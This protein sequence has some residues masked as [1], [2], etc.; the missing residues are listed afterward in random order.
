MARRDLHNSILLAN[1]L[2]L[3]AIAN[4]EN[5]VGEIIDRQGFDSLEFVLVV[6]A[7]TDGTVTPLIEHGDESN[8]SDAVA[9]PDAQLL[10]TE[11]AAALGAVGISNI[12]YAGNKR[13]VRLT[14]DTS[15][16]A[17][18]S[19]EALA[20]KSALHVEGST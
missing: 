14:A 3:T 10:G 19:V 12:G 1:A 4:G 5:A 13:Y 11:A 20:I 15:A 18:L 17:T 9:V 8:L 16:T 7:F 6:N 2:T